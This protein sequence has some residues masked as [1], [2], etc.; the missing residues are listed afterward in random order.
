MVIHATA[1]GTTHAIDR[2]RRVLLTRAAQ[3]D[4]ILARGGV[5]PV[6]LVLEVAEAVVLVVLCRHA[7]AVGRAGR[8]AAGPGGLLAVVVAADAVQAARDRVL[9]AVDGLA[10]RVAGGAL[11]GC[12]EGRRGQE[13]EDRGCE[14]IHVA[15]WSWWWWYGVAKLRD[16]VLSAQKKLLVWG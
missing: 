1:N 4:R 11:G 15:W 8:D 7:R 6:D 13:S 9:L 3:V 10:A 16:G 2:Q 5:G 12:G 14:G